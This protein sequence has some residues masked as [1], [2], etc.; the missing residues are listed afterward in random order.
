MVQLETKTNRGLMVQQTLQYEDLETAWVWNRD[1][2]CSGADDGSEKLAR[3][4]QADG[5]GTELLTIML[6]EQHQ[7][8]SGADEGFGTMVAQQFAFARNLAWTAEQSMWA[9]AAAEAAAAGAVQRQLQHEKFFL[10][11][12]SDE[13]KPTI[14]LIIEAAK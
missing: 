9:T 1:T 7:P 13:C 4:F 10:S 6:H 11:V 3:K 2:T 14:R 12:S 5:Q 8:H